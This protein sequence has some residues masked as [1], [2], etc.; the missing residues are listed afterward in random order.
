MKKEREYTGEIPGIGS[1][2]IPNSKTKSLLF[3]MA[4]STG[5]FC[6]LPLSEFIRSDE[7]LIRKVDAPVFTPPPPPLTQMEKIIKR[8]EVPARPKPRLQKK[9]IKLRPSP[10]LATLEVGPGD[11]KSAFSLTNF[12]PA[13]DGFGNELIFAM[14]ELDRNPSVLRPGTLRYPSHL[15]RKGL[16]GEVKLLVLIDERGK[17]KVLEVVSFSHPDFVPASRQAAETSL[18]EPPKRN[19]EAVKVQFYLPIRFNLFE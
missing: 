8:L 11:F 6:L 12:N 4:L 1:E 19:G 5:L 9:E 7:W 13:P 14:H 3:S 2:L 15:K 18:Y 16:E 10:L 17:V